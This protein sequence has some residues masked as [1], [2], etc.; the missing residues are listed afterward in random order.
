[1]DGSSL[2]DKTAKAVASTSK[3]ADHLRISGASTC[4]KQL[5]NSPFG[6][7]LR[8]LILQNKIEEPLVFRQIHGDWGPCKWTL[9][10]W[11]DIFRDEKLTV[12]YGRQKWDHE[13][14]QWES[15]CGNLEIT[16][17]RMIEWVRN[18]YNLPIDQ[19]SPAD[20]WMYYDYKY[21]PEVIHLK[22][23]SEKDFLKVNTVCVRIST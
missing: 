1:M 12:R 16:W 18:E 13:S 22:S 3:S 4:G 23:E 15:L 7:E 19:S 14:P 17:T 10:D 2:E 9:G 5:K 20:I 11:G 6:E 21:L 8:E